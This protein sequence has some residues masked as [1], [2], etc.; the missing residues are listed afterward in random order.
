M[1]TSNRTI[2][3]GG[4]HSVPEGWDLIIRCKLKPRDK[5]LKPWGE[6][7]RIHKNMHGMSSKNNS[8]SGTYIIRRRPQVNLKIQNLIDISIRT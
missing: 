7:E 6:W 3:F 4:T 5:I 8:W 1:R 2:I